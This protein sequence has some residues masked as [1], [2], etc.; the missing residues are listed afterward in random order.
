MLIKWLKFGRGDPRKAEGYVLAAT[1][2][3]GVVRAS[4]EVLRG[5]VEQ[6]AHVASS[7]KTVHRYSSGV[8]SWAPDDKPTP[9][10]IQ[11]TIDDFE[12]AAFA[13][14]D[15]SRYCWAVVQ[16]V[17]D[18]GSVHLHILV[19][20]VDL[21][22]GK[23]LNVAPPGWR[24]TFD[25][26]RDALNYQH[27]WARP[28]DPARARILQ[29]G[30]RALVDAAA[31][32]A[33]FKTPS[34]FKQEITNWLVERITAG[35]ISDRDGIVASLSEWGEINR[36]GKDYVSLRIPELEKP[37][38][39]KGAI[40][41]QD[42]AVTEEP[43]RA[44]V[45]PGGEAQPGR[46]RADGVDLERAAEARAKL[47]DAIAR[48][49]RFNLENFGPNE[50]ES[51]DEREHV[52]TVDSDGDQRIDG[53]DGRRDRAIA[54][55]PAGH[56]GPPD[57]G[58]REVDARHG[59]GTDDRSRGNGQASGLGDDG[60]RSDSGN[61]AHD[62]Q[63]DRL[64]H[65]GRLP[66][67]VL[68][69]LGILEVDGTLVSGRVQQLPSVQGAGARLGNVPDRGQTAALPISRV[70]GDENGIQQQKRKRRNDDRGRPGHTRSERDSG[71]SGGTRR[72]PPFETLT[73]SGADRPGLRV[74]RCLGRERLPVLQEAGYGA[75][76][77]KRRSDLLPSIEPR[78][79]S[80]DH[81]LHFLYTR[82]RHGLDRVAEFTVTRARRAI[83]AFRESVGI[84]RSVD[85]DLGAAGAG[86]VA[87]AAGYA[88]HARAEHEAAG[89]L[90]ADIVRRAGEVAARIK[91][92]VALAA[93]VAPR[94]EAEERLSLLTKSAGAVAVS[95]MAPSPRRSYLEAGR[96]IH[97]GAHGMDSLEVDAI[98]AEQLIDDG[99]H[100]QDL[101]DAITAAS[102]AAIGA[103]GYAHQVVNEF[104]EKRE[105]E[106]APKQATEPVQAPMP[107]REPEPEHD[108][109]QDQDWEQDDAEQKPDEPMQPML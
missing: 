13:G 75:D 3:N 28:D 109:E 90:G 82:V 51:G 102:P 34:D 15:P 88:D 22:T 14:L 32:R 87:A 48:R 23:A 30:H 5:N 61:N 45:A 103:P 59:A 72:S 4:V 68:R 53:G 58:A 50:P 66:G 31:L 60:P 38:R 29:P 43:S 39:F 57:E 80:I 67:I 91:A 24:H 18:D 77:D 35:T 8:I 16:H 36:I 64:G 101:I 27:G 71:G 99:M 106:S 42:F 104:V 98:V 70:T 73:D 93:L 10:E 55:A 20:R 25:H 86:L 47:A 11:Q 17:E 37:L 40:Y 108:P 107:E 96:A 56:D 76:R 78:F 79:G 81:A 62:A 83:S 100:P 92:R 52:A 1:D 21:K 33:G 95:L 41:G 97:A 63:D 19:A 84:T 7:L 9:E 54:A 2:A 12:K 46:S 85:L 69:D 89:R 49:A 6:F 26:L 74:C 94:T 44:D 65:A 105:L